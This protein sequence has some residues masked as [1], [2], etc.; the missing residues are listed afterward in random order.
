MT[1][2]Q[3]AALK[4]EYEGHLAKVIDDLTLALK[5]MREAEQMKESKCGVPPW[6]ETVMRL[7]LYSEEAA[8][9]VWNGREPPR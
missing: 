2:E 1:P 7:R 4:K 6:R 9:D 5:W 3:R 8:R